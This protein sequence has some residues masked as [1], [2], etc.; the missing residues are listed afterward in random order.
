MI[1]AII[2]PGTLHGTENTSTSRGSCET[3]IKESLEWSALSVITLSGL[4]QGELS[5]S[6][7]NTGEL[8]IKTELL[9]DTAGDEKTSAVSS[10]PVGETLGDAVCC[11]L[12]AVS[13]SEDLVTGD[14][15]GHDL[16]NNV[17]VGE[18]NDEPVLRSIVLVLGLGD[19]TLASVVIGLSLLTTLV[20][21]L[22]T[23][24]LC[25]QKFEYI[26]RKQSYL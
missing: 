12:V 17:A 21:S 10:S 22:V 26:L 5:I 8:L 7:L 25:Q 24:I 18:T 9:E 23:T 2:L 1:D 3:D 20:L 13:G 14:L 15:G 19:E 6:L 11:E 16:H 4:S